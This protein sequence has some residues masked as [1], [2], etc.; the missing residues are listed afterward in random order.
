MEQSLWLQKL[1]MNLNKKVMEERLFT[2]AEVQ[3]MCSRSYMR[4]MSIQHNTMT[5][6]NIKPPKV[7]SEWVKDLIDNCPINK[8]K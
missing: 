7:F 4:G 8:F 1:V 5:K 3:E 2:K 6:K